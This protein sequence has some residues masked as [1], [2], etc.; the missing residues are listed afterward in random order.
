VLKGYVIAVVIVSNDTFVQS[1]VCRTLLRNTTCILEHGLTELCSERADQNLS[2]PV[3]GS[4]PGSCYHRC[5]WMGWVRRKHQ[6][7]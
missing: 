6:F 4:R 7:M 3:R 1:V 2:R 5:H